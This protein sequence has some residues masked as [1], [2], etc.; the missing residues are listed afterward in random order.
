IGLLAVPGRYVWSPRNAGPYPGLEPAW[1]ENLLKVPGDLLVLMRAVSRRAG[2]TGR[3]LF[4]EHL[5]PFVVPYSSKVRFVSSRPS[6][7]YE[8]LDEAGRPEE[9]ME[10]VSLAVPL[11]GFRGTAYEYFGDSLVMLQEEDDRARELLKK[12]DVTHILT[13]DKTRI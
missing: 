4:A 1:G 3:L 8:S 7:T 2:E 6:Y 13:D 9:G 5:S 10:R 12:Y 11:L